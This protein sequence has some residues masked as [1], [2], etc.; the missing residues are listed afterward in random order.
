MLRCP[1]KR[2]I[3][4]LWTK[5]VLPVASFSGKAKLNSSTFTEELKSERNHYTYS[6][7]VIAMFAENTTRTQCLSIQLGEKP[8]YNVLNLYRP[9][10]L[11][12]PIPPGYLLGIIHLRMMLAALE[13]GQHFLHSLLILRFHIQLKIDVSDSL[14]GKNV[15]LDLV[16]A[17]LQSILTI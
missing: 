11:D 7:R 15:C 13:C 4:E 1:T 8:F 10:N 6:A 12:T 14:V 5:C 3:I 2:N 9:H 17:F 16:H